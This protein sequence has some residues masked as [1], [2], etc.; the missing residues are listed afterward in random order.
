MEGDKE[1]NHSQQKEKVG[2]TLILLESI[3]KQLK[4][5]KQMTL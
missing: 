5:N 4:K 2:L 1:E 3:P